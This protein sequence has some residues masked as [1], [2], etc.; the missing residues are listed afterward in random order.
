MFGWLALKNIWTWDLK[1][2]ISSYLP[3]NQP[4]WL[5][6]RLKVTLH[7]L[8]I[9]IRKIYLHFFFQLGGLGFW[10]ACTF[11]W[12]DAKLRNEHFLDCNVVRASFLSSL[13]FVQ[14]F[15]ISFIL[16]FDFWDKLY[17][18]REHTIYCLHDLFR[19]QCYCKVSF[20]K[21]ILEIIQNFHVP[22]LF[23]K[24]ILFNLMIY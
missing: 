19:P 12:I 24:I 15:W 8:S 4:T 3:S 6:S 21:I 10:A 23:G 7:T 1:V 14:H 22:F 5:I 17:F 20:Y 9:L 16:D 2:E 11:S 18:Q 13:L